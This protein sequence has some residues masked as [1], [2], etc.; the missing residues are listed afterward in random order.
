MEMEVMQ[1]DER[2]ADS[3]VKYTLEGHRPSEEAI[4]RAWKC[5]FICEY[6]GFKKLT[7]D[8]GEILRY[9]GVLPEGAIKELL[10][11]TYEDVS[12]LDDKQLEKLVKNDASKG[13]LVTLALMLTGRCQEECKICY[14]NRKAHPDELVWGEHKQLLDQAR[15]AGTKIIYTAGMGEPT[16]D[17][18]FLKICEY[19]KKHN[20]TFLFFT[21]GIVFSDEETAQRT[22]GMSCRQLAE[23]LKEY[24]IN[25]Y[26]SFWDTDPKVLAEMGRVNMA[27]LLETDAVDY[28]Y[29]GGS[30]RLPKGLAMLLEVMPEGKLG[31]QFT[32]AKQN[33]ANAT[34]KILPFIR[35]ARKPVAKGGLGLGVYLEPLIHSGKNRG[36]LSNDAEPQY[37]ARVQKDEWVRDGKWCSEDKNPTKLTINTL[38]FL[39]PGLAINPLEATCFMRIFLNAI[40]PETESQEDFLGRLNVREGGKKGGKIRSLFDMRFLDLQVLTL[41]AAIG[42]Q[43]EKVCVC[44]MIPRMVA[45]HMGLQ[46][47]TTGKRATPPLHS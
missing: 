43:K 15:K 17:L 6:Y 16:L 23:T 4:M 19:A 2:Y 29:P 13:W 30:L 22:F 8:G 47:Q 20:L 41:F 10:L 31:L 14:T 35:W 46:K 25:M 12:K 37:L 21:N 7:G 33:Q 32:I 28:A 9:A 42:H 3:G 44:E 36:V 5:R 38:G 18:S 27:R 34:E 1:M 39:Q 45:P 11:K 24:P 40:S 26:F